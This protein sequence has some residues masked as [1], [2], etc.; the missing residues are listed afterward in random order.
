MINKN[1]QFTARVSYVISSFFH[2][3]YC[4]PT[5]SWIYLVLPSFLVQRPAHSQVDGLLPYNPHP[6]LYFFDFYFFLVSTDANSFDE[7][8]SKKSRHGP[9]R[10]PALLSLIKSSGARHCIERGGGYFVLFFFLLSF[11]SSSSSSS[12]VFFYFLSC[13]LWDAIRRIEMQSLQYQGVR[14]KAMGP[15]DGGG[16][17]GL[18]LHRFIGRHT[19][20]GQIGPSSMT[21]IAGEVS[22]NPKPEGPEAGDREREREKSQPTRAARKW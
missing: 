14:M 1:L 22:D 13:G 19:L 12:G 20:H 21:I 8:D 16:G 3:F 7:I 2:L 15:K 18:G 4:S 10:S 17:G 6:S 9:P 11:S 5:S